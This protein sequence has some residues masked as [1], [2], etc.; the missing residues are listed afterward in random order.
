MPDIIPLTIDLPAAVECQIRMYVRRPNESVAAAAARLIQEKLAEDQARSEGIVRRFE[1]SSAA[2]RQE[3]AD[4]G[5][6]EDELGEL[7]QHELDES[8]R[9]KQDHWKP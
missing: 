2:F 3:V 4:S 8:R 6:T 5:M 9:E 7:F 1:Q